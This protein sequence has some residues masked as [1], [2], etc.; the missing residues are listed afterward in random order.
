M[1][2]GSEQMYAGGNDPNNREPLWTDMNPNSAGY[3]FVKTINSAKSAHK[4][5]E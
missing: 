4:I 3:S 1:Y 2:Y 5:W